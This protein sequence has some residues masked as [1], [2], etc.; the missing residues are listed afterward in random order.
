MKTTATDK[1][2]PAGS[3]FLIDLPHYRIDMFLA[4]NCAGLVV[5]FEPLGRKK[6]LGDRREGWGMKVLQELGYSVMAIM[7]KEC[8]WYRQTDLQVF[9]AQMRARG[10]FQGFKQVI[11]YGG[12]MGG[13]A[14][15]AHADAVSATIALSINPQA[16]L[17]A[18]LAPWENRFNFVN[19]ADWE[20]DFTN[21]A[22]GFKNVRQA[23][24]I[25]DPLFTLDARHVQLLS[26]DNPGL[27]K[28]KIPVVGHL[29]PQWMA[30]MGLLKPTIKAIF[31][32]QFSELAFYQQVR[33]R[34]SIRR[35][36]QMLIDNPRVAK[37]RLFTM[38]VQRYAEQHGFPMNTRKEH[39]NA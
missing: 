18:Q 4:H 36:W 7:F 37:S 15:L 20:G 2:T 32:G 28:L 14:A 5:T 17:S 12:S 34:R 29:M 26:A 1:A 39:G 19:R 30:E 10:F 6:T 38:I 21:A 27:I 24:V 3:R 13:F 8:D 33:K 25:Y 22:V 9:F 35:Y 23:Y 31:S 16:S 11:T